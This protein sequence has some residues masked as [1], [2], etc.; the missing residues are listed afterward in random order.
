MRARMTGS[1][2]EH[3]SVRAMASTLA[4]REGW[5]AA[6][7]LSECFAGMP[8]FH[9]ASLRQPALN[10][11]VFFQPVD[12]PTLVVAV[13]HKSEE[14]IGVAQLL[15]VRLS[16]A[17]GAGTGRVVAYTQCVG[18]APA[19]RRRGIARALM[20]SCEETATS[21]AGASTVDE[22]WLSVAVGNEAALSLY[23]SMGYKRLDVRLDNVLMS[24]RLRGSSTGVSGAAAQRSGT[25][26]MSAPLPGDEDTERRS[27]TQ[28]DGAPPRIPVGVD[29]AGQ[30]PPGATS[31]GGADDAC[32][33]DSA[34]SGLGWGALGANLGTQLLYVGVAAL[35]VSLLLA[36][37]GGPTVASLLGGAP[38]WELPTASSAAS[39][40]ADGAASV[41]GVGLLARAVAECSLGA[42]VSAA[43]LH[44]LGVLDEA[45]EAGAV[46]GGLQYTPAQ[47]VQMRPLWQIAAGE[48][49]APRALAAVA[50]WQL[51]IALAEELYYRGFLMS[52]GVLAI[53]AGVELGSG[54]GFSGASLPTTLLVAREVLPLLVSA[55]IFGAV[56]TEFVPDDGGLDDSKAR[57]F[58]VTGAYGLA[59]ACHRPLAVPMLHVPAPSHAI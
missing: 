59:C 9:Y 51:C 49:S 53:S 47:A 7:I 6:K 23:E 50:V 5:A 57:W 2:N 54:G 38:L 39:S 42:G 27:T 32:G 29:A 36:P 10:A 34:L 24:K 4:D 20:R 1:G 31:R 12:G 3:Y 41:G 26:A 8:L 43:E 40:A 11:N 22:A 35:G 25:P 58:A 19:A 56:H 44:R 33:D 15:R 52:A 13:D 37:F 28:A 21:W 17:A 55:A 46:D 14:V 48:S 45:S 18:V 16:Q 30:L